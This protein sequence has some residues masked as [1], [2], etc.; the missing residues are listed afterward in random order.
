MSIIIII[1]YILASI[2]IVHVH[3]RALLLLTR[4]ESQTDL[5]S[6]KSSYN[7]NNNNY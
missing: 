1:I 4:Y 3:V 6:V 5:Q 2:F 7:K